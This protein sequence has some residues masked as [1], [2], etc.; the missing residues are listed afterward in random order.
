MRGCCATGGRE[1][2]LQDADEDERREKSEL[3]GDKEEAKKRAIMIIMMLMV[4]MRMRMR[5]K[6]EQG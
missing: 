3:L 1:K 6:D 4:M 2:G 5:V